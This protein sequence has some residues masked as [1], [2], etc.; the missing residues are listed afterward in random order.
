MHWRVEG[1]RAKV[2]LEISVMADTRALV[3]LQ[4]A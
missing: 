4:E 1:L 3:W 2:W